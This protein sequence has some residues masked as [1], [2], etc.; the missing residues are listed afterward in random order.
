MRVNCPAKTVLS[1]L[2][3]KQG[4]ARMTLPLVVNTGNIKIMTVAS[5]ENRILRMLVNQERDYVKWMRR[6]L[7]TD[8]NNRYSPAIRHFRRKLTTCPNK[9]SQGPDSHGYNEEIAAVAVFEADSFPRK[10]C[11]LLSLL[12]REF[13]W[14][15]WNN[16]DEDWTRSAT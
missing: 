16:D 9:N 10:R 13:G 4:N 8:M 7:H 14:R 11:K 12:S 1:N 3:L 15:T 6:E 2:P 5:L